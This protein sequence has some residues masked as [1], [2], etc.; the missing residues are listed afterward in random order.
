MKIVAQALTLP[1][2]RPFRI[3]REATTQARNVLLTISD[4]HF[5]GYGEAAPSSFYSETADAVLAS[6]A[7][8][9]PFFE[10]IQVDSAEDIARIWE[11]VWPQLAPSRAA[12]CAVDVAL[13]DYLGKKRGVSVARLA[14][15]CPPEARTS[16]FTIGIST[17]EELREKVEEVRS[18]PI[19]KIKLGA[20]GDLEP[21]RYIARET[22][23]TLFVDANCA[24]SQAPV[25][26]ISRELAALRVEFIEQP[27]PPA[28]DDRMPEILRSSELPILADESCV[29]PEDV[30]RMPGRFSGF[31][32]KLVK[33]G[34]ITPALRMLR[35]GRELGLKIMVG[36]M[37]ESSVL[38]SAGLVIAQKTDYADLDGN[39]LIANDPFEGIQMNLGKLRALDVPGL[40]V[41]P[42]APLR[43]P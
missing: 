5:T 39:W 43:T 26:G 25:G 18:F 34:G 24:W 13:W 42:A 29:L 30:E 27:L 35:R 4:G 31:N 12:Q 2:K 33:C 40:G 17:P 10:S 15:G 32:I 6:L 14:F 19:I 28:E 37:L 11:Q 38:I 8:L 9:E 23:A 41:S 36:C 21:V 16:S 22:R 1:A 3:S 20:D 7:R